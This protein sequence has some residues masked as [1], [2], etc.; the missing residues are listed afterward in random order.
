MIGK[1]V[2]R[3]DG[4]RRDGSLVRH[5]EAELFRAQ[6]LGARI[7]YEKREVR[8]TADAHKDAGCVREESTVLGDLVSLQQASRSLKPVSVRARVRMYFLDLKLLQYIVML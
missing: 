6:T 2:T 3:P 5:S 7:V 4:S 1:S 8:I